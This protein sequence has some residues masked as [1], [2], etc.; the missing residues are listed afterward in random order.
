MRF[1]KTLTIAKI[2]GHAGDPMIEKA[3]DLADRATYLPPDMHFMTFRHECLFSVAGD[4]P[5]PWSPH[6][7]KLLVQHFAQRLWTQQQ[8]RDP[9]RKPNCTEAWLS[10]EGAYRE[11]LGSVKI[12][13]SLSLSA[14]FKPDLGLFRTFGVDLST[15]PG[16]GCRC[17]SPCVGP[18]GVEAIFALP[19]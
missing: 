17:P 1:G 5:R 3:D 7:C 15:S 13:G 14:R 9:L 10:T 2:P 19:Q 8:Q 12:W 4:P 18:V 16:C 6:V 11:V